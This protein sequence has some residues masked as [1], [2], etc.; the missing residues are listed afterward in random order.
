MAVVGAHEEMSDRGTVVAPERHYQQW[1]T[2]PLRKNPQQRRGPISIDSSHKT[3]NTS[4]SFTNGVS[5]VD[6]AR[7]SSFAMNSNPLH[8]TAS[9]GNLGPVFLGADWT[10]FSLSTIIVA[11]RLYTRLCIT[12]NFWLDDAAIV[13]TQVMRLSSF[14]Q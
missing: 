2:T 14:Y 4:A 8:T 3:P 11:L 7:H 1:M 5:T 12:R 9:G 10:V 6:A 13:L